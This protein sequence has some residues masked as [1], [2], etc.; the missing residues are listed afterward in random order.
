[1][2]EGCLCAFSAAVGLRRVGFFG[3]SAHFFPGIEIMTSEISRPTRNDTDL[4]DTVRDAQRGDRDAFG[5]LVV[6]YQGTVYGIAY[7]R[8]RNH[9]KSQELCQDVFIQAM[10]KIGQ[11]RDPSCFGA[12]VRAIADRMAINRVAR[13]ASWSPPT[14]RV[15]IPFA[16]NGKRR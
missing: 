16:W 3:L 14:P 13:A 10:R 6:R 1:M 12:W 11:L 4:R 7:R 5:R 15:L 8:L 9:A 2:A